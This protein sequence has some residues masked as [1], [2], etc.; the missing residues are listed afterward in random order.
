MSP[1]TSAQGDLDVRNA[2]FWDELCGSALAR[3]VGITDATPSSL[4]RFDAAYMSM[5]PYLRSYI[6]ARLDGVEVLEIGLGYGTLSGELVGR[7][8][9]YHGLDIAAGPVEMVRHRLRLAGRADPEQRVVQ[10]SALD[11]PHADGS[12]DRVFTIGC[13][14][15]TGDIPRAV[16][17]VHRVLRPGGVAVVMLYHANSLRQLA[18]VRLPS[19]L[20]GRRSE[21][22]VAGMYDT[23]ARGQAAPH[24][25]YVSRG[26]VRRI[27]APFSETSIQARNFDSTRFLRREWLLGTVDRVLGLDL[28]ITARK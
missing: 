28:Y 14:H 2:E 17:E 20:R 7:G 19:L 12:F 13:L 23:N 5:Y 10:G 24:A 9:D 21:E 4:S 1:E 27:F 22:E 6:P 25:E 8:A 15:H 26:D 11:V 18:R 3:Q 16:S